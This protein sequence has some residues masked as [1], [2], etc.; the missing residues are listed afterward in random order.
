MQELHEG[1]AITQIGPYTYGTEPIS[2]VIDDAVTLAQEHFAEVRESVPYARL[3]LDRQRYEA[4]EGQKALRT[5]TAR[6]GGALV[7]YATF[8][9]SAPMHA[10]SELHAHQDALFLSKAHRRGCTGMDLIDFCDSMLAAEGVSVVHH[11][12]TEAN[13]FSVLLKRRGYA[14]SHSVY[15]RRL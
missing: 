15:S 8:I 12:V 4:F 14:L 9:L 7:G 1:L 3:D 10:A 2:R 5:F 13:D 11:T 6:C